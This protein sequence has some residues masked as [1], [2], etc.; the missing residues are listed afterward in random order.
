MTNNI[1]QSVIIPHQTDIFRMIFLYVGQGDSTLCVI[2]D[3]GTWKYLLID[4]NVDVKSGGINLV[5][6]L[7]DLFINNGER[8]SL[9]VFVNTHPHND[10]LSAIKDIYNEVGIRQIWHSGHKPGKEH[11]DAFQNLQ[12]VMNEVGEGNTFRLFGSQEK[13]KLEQQ[14]I[15][16]GDI[17]YNILAP[18][19][20][21]TDDIEG[22]KPEERARRI[23][24]QCGVIAFSYS[25]NKYQVIV[26]GDADYDAW[27]KHITQYHKSR[28]PS[29][30]F[31]A[32][33]HGSNSFFWKGDPQGKEAYTKHLDTINPKYIIVS[34][35]TQKQ[36]KFGHPDDDAM[37]M[38]EK[39]TGN[40]DNLFHL[41]KKPECVFVD[42]YKNGD[43]NIY[44]D[45]ALIDTYGYKDDDGGSN[46]RDA[47]YSSIIIPKTKLD[48][49]P[50]GYE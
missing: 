19:E 12:W 40:C 11:D 34:A 17:D 13:N 32:P 1:A 26:P 46:E 30:V 3:N 5:S 18:A 6:M 39:Q 10:H 16:I 8:N 49:K 22:E 21:V 38:Y 45:D 50:M 37:K 20:Y 44:T 41:G 9:D 4:S 25:N 28:L 27:E 35:P 7:K 14:V 2:P 23:H 42:I 48:D 31:R 24:E 15:K 43:I 47:M 29:I 33:H 36:S